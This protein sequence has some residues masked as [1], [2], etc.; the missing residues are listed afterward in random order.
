MAGLGQISLVCP[1]CGEPATASVRGSAIWDGFEGE[2]SVD[3]RTEWRLVQ[4]TSCWRPILLV[5]EDYGRG[6]EDVG[7]PVVVFPAPRRLSP[8]VPAPLRR[9]WEEARNC[10]DAKAYTAC[11]V[12]VRRVLEGTCQDQGVEEKNLAAGLRRLR[13]EGRMDGL[14][15]EWADALRLL[16]NESAHFTGKEVSREDAEDSL[17][18][19][20]ALL[21]HLYVLRERF[22]EFQSRR[23]R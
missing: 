12:M 8:K 5:R 19:G 10:F 20:E 18:F 7:D 23:A 15:A 22:A 2:R 11:G 4:C 14:L 21:D 3:P 13:D 9:E 17:A 1:N 16:G 6:F